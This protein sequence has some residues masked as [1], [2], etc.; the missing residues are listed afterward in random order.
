MKPRQ[1]TKEFAV[2]LAELAP[3][4][5][6]LN[7]AFA[8]YVPIL[9]LHRFQT[10]DGR[11]TGHSGQFVADAIRYV[12]SIGYRIVTA[13]E[14]VERH[15]AGEPVDRLVAFTIDDGYFD[16]MDI[17]AQVFM[18][19]QAPATIYLTTGLI[20][21]DFW[22]IEAQI[23]LIFDNA[24]SD[25]SFEAAGAHWLVA[26]DDSPERK[27]QR[28]RVLVFDVKNK[29]IDHA[30]TLIKKLSIQ[31]NVPLPEQI[32]PNYQ[33]MTWDQARAAE[34]RGIR[35]GAHTVRHVTLSVESR[36]V[37]LQELQRSTQTLRRELAEPSRVFCYP[38]GRTSDFGKREIDMLKDLGYIGAMTAEA[39]YFEPGRLDEDGLF[40]VPRF[41]FPSTLH[42]LK[43]I[44]M[45][46][47]VLSEYLHQ[48]F[49]PRRAR[50]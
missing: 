35:F 26:P 7:R 29:P 50:S 30:L 9:M 43:K 10:A 28:K 25:F 18:D 45:R 12:R 37:A 32:P 15:L 17:G 3:V 21:G 6:L 13:D 47:E 33:P 31:A 14:I 1:A 11:S 24:H 38:T 36:E 39:G 20:A 16:Q 34:A 40:R 42:D 5:H 48:R 41:A 44:M 22:P 46:L 4:R 8:G 2:N 19:H 23:R 49:R 27:R